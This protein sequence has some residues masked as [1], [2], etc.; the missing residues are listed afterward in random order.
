MTV[1]GASMPHLLEPDFLR[2]LERLSIAARHVQLGLAKGER[3]SKRKGSSVE[4]ADYRDYVQGDDLRHVDWNIYG[5]LDALY[6]KLFQE[7]EDLTVHLLVDASRSMGF[8]APSKI[9][10][11]ARLAAAIGYVGLV[12]YDRVSAE[13]FS[14]AGVQRLV[15]C[16]GKA[17]AHKL[18]DFM[19]RI[20]AEGGT[21]LEQNT[22]SYVIRNRSKGVA[23]LF[24]DFLDPNG[25]EGCLKRLRQSGSDCFAVHILS[26]AEI[27]P[28]ITGDLRLLD[29]ETQEYVEVSASPALLK[30]YKENLSGFCEAIRRFCLA[31]G[32]GYIFAPTDGPFDRLT[33]DVLRSGGLF[34]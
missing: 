24:S 26:R 32:I 27:D 13:A 23:V 8:G 15:P 21:Q 9:E 28:A 10:F 11:A 5:R 22:K 31:R 33:L 6:L 25:F 18:L 3:K 1:D 17:S 19:S 34:K 20:V 30:R 7:H 4:F 12:G 29:S 14:A 16:R 2:K